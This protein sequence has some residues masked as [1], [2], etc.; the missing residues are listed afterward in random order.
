MTSCAL[1]TSTKAKHAEVV[2]P[3]P[4]ASEKAGARSS[5]RYGRRMARKS[6]ALPRSTSSVVNGGSAARCGAS[7]ARLSG[8]NTETR[9][10]AFGYQGDERPERAHVIIRR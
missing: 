4:E 5:V 1:P 8:R 3:D 2:M 6:D 9:R 7:G 10:P